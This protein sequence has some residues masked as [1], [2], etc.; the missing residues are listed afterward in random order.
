MISVY[1]YAVEEYVPV[2]ASKAIITTFR[3]LLIT[4]YPSKVYFSTE[5]GASGC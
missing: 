3:K 4:C 1:I 2:Q 5:L